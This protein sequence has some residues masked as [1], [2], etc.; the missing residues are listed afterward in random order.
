MTKRFCWNCRNLVSR[1]IRPIMTH[2]ISQRTSE[3]LLRRS[4]SLFF[5]HLFPKI[6]TVRNF[7][8]PWYLHAI[9]KYLLEMYYGTCPRL[10]LNAP[11]RSLKT[12]LANTYFIPWLLGKDPSTKVMVVTY[13]DDLSSTLAK[14]LGDNLK[15]ASGC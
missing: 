1:L 10:I 15:L 11:P 6:D 9:S 3:A 14:V 7:E 5:T 8:C 4:P 12:S 13:G 2:N